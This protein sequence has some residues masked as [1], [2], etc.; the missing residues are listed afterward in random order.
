MLNVLAM[1]TSDDREAEDR[2]REA[3]ADEGREPDA[4]HRPRRA[5]ISW[6]AAAIGATTRVDQ[7][8]PSPYAA[9]TWE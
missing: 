4:G 6:T 7:I 9:P 3:L 1:A 5:A 2:R 8:R